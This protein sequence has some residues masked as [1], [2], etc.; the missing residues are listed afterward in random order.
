MSDELVVKFPQDARTIEIEFEFSAIRARWD[1]FVLRGLDE[2]GVGK[3][4]SD[5]SIRPDRA[6]VPAEVFDDNVTRLI[7]QVG[8]FAPE[9]KVDYQVVVHLS[10]DGRKL[11]DP[12]T[13][14]GSLESADFV[15][16]AGY[17]K[18]VREEA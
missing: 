15:S 5:D 18:L 4:W 9:A 8:F 13:C 7:W 14:Q 2:R 3:G 12:V 6:V 17:A 10:A 11:V 1:V 16:R